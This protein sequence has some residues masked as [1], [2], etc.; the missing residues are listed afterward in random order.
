MCTLVCLYLLLCFFGS[1]SSVDSFRPIPVCLCF[2]LSYFNFLL[3]FRC[4]F[5]NEI[6]RVKPNER[7]GVDDLGGVG[8][9][10][11]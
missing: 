1:F 8:I 10:Q 11:A 6:G 9:G 4:L 7:G 5:P 2:T 3:F